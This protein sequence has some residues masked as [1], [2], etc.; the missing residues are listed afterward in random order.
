MKTMGSNIAFAIFFV[1]VLALT[2][3]GNIFVC[4]TIVV[5]RQLRRQT[6]NYFIFFL[7]ISDIAV[8]LFVLPFR[9][10]MSLHNQ[11][12]CASLGVCSFYVIIDTTC[13]VASVTNLLVIAMDRRFM[14]GLPYRYPSLMNRRRAIGICIG[15]WVYSHLWSWA[16]AFTWTKN[17]QFSISLAGK[18]CG[19]INK[20]FYYPFITLVYF[21]PLTIMGICYA[22]ILS[23]ANKQAK[24]IQRHETMVNDKG[25]KKR[26]RERKATKTLTII[27]GAFVLCWL[28]NCILGVASSLCPQCFVYLRTNYEPLFMFLLITFVEVLPPLNSTM[29]P[30]IYGIHNQHFRNAFK[31][32]ITRK[33]AAYLNDSD[34][35]LTR[36]TMHRR[37][38]KKPKKAQHDATRAR[39]AT[40]ETELLQIED[41]V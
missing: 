18:R 20:N 27:Y 35:G 31:E 29:N 3:V 9:I 28:P 36:I 1:F 6:T 25:H 23:I 2:L 11:A 41:P 30:F 4:S 5:C 17:P 33:K 12:F 38:T 8:G 14:I 34:N 15:I 26:T 10:Y 40:G 21:I 39:F 7:A 37:S 22:S 19:N 32:F 24:G 16:S 13:S